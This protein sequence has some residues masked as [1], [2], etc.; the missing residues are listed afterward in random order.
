MRER[1]A[2]PF[3][4]WAG[5]KRQLLPQLRRFVPAGFSAYFEPFVGSGALFFDLATERRLACVPVTLSDNNADLIGTY[6]ALA[7]HPAATIRHLRRLAEE[8]ARGGDDFYY[9]VRDRRFNVARAERRQGASHGSYPVELA[10]QLLYL[11][12]TCFNGL[13]RQNAKGDFNVPVG[14]YAN[15]TICDAE[16]LR[17]VSGLIAQP[18]IH[19]VQ[20]PFDWVL[21]R[22]NPGNFVYFDPPYAPVSETAHFRSYTAEGFSPKDQERLQR[23]AIELA[24]RGVHVVLSN[25]VAPQIQ[26]LYESDEARGAGFVAH[27]VPAR[28]AINCDGSSRGTIDEFVI[29]TVPPR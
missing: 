10:A 3:L 20:A 23:T 18:N 14:R 25:S 4:K 1:P 9:E 19:L 22:A 27:R 17:R 28:R 11:N 2:L 8:H 5:G 26:R 6:Q 24:H 7:R 16:N 21:E 13:F 12:R 15:P 29:S